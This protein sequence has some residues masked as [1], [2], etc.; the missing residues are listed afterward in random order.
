MEISNE[1]HPKSKVYQ[2]IAD[3][4]EP[5]PTEA[6]RELDKWNRHNAI[7]IFTLTS[8]MDLLQI[9]LIENC[10]SLAE[11]LRKLDSIYCQKSETNIMLVH[12]RYYQ[13][14]ISKDSIAQ[15]IAKVE[16]IVREHQETREKISNTSIMTKSLR[17][18]PSK[19]RNF[20]QAWLSMAEDKQTIENLSAPLLDEEA[21]LTASEKDEEALTTATFR[22]INK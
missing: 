4:S 13:Y 17:S 7:A 10:E 20:R 22:N 2:C 5:K 3:S 11:I 21:N 8:T 19:H 14:K 1:V 12:E 15:H 16:N 18:L 9:T 6:G